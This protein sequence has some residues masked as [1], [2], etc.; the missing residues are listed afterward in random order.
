MNYEN[1]AG[2]EA[3]NS[4]YI[5]IEEYTLILKHELMCEDLT[6]IQL[7]EPIVVKYKICAGEPYAVGKVTEASYVV[8]Q[9]LN[10]MKDE[11]I[12]KVEELC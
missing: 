9:M 4:E 12:R 11:L 8:N 7:D 3:T 5:P 10:R 6:K 2:T 1:V